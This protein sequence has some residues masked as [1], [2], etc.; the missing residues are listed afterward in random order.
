[1]WIGRDTWVDPLKSS[2]P[3]VPL[4]CLLVS[5]LQQCLIRKKR[6]S[7][8]KNIHP[9]VCAEGLAWYETVSALRGHPIYHPLPIPPTCQNCSLWL[10]QLFFRLKQLLALPNSSA[11]KVG[12]S[13]LGNSCQRDGGKQLRALGEILSLMTAEAGGLLLVMHHKAYTSG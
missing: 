13:Q 9:L 12:P 2:Y 10:T 3:L 4:C 6:P 7:T 1:M 8:V 11:R 5:G